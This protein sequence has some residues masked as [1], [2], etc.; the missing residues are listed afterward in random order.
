MSCEA[1][2]NIVSGLPYILCRTFFTFDQ[3]YYVVCL[4]VYE[5]LYWVDLF[6]YVTMEGG[7]PYGVPTCDTI[8]AAG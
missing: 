5:L 2:V 8:L 4:T 7:C 1:I 3:V 6:G